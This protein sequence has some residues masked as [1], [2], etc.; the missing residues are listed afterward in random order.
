[1]VRKIHLYQDKATGYYES[2]MKSMPPAAN[3]LKEDLS[4]EEVLNIFSFSSPYFNDILILLHL[5]YLVFPLPTAKMS[6]F[7]W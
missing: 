4:V 1:M 2:V 5:L 6:C 3:L 7:T